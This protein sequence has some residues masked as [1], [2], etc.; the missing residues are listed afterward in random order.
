MKFEKTNIELYDHTR[1]ELQEL[2]ED[3]ESLEETI[4]RL[5]EYYRE[6]EK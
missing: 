2:N 3:G 4:V 6:W 1:K 5:I